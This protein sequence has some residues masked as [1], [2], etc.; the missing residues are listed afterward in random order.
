ME[1]QKNQVMAAD[2]ATRIAAKIGFSSLLRNS[3]IHLLKQP[4][5]YQAHPSSRHLD[6]T[7]NPFSQ[8]MHS[9]LFLCLLLIGP[10]L[11]SCKEE[12]AHAGTVPAHS[13]GQISEGHNGNT[14]APSPSSISDTRE[15]AGTA[16]QQGQLNLLGKD[17]GRN[18]VELQAETDSTNQSTVEQKQNTAPTTGTV[19]RRLSPISYHK[20]SN[21]AH[22][23]RR[24]NGYG[25]EASSRQHDWLRSI[26]ANSIA[27]TPFGFQ[28]G[29]KSNQLVGFGPEDEPGTRDRS[30]KLDD[31]AA[32]VAS[33]HARG[34]RVMLKPHIWSSDFWDGS[35]WHGTID[36]T[37]AEDHRQWWNSY[38]KLILFYAEFAEQTKC[39]YYCIGTE[40]VQMTTTYPQ[41]WRTLIADV[42]EIFKGK[43]SYA[44]HWEQE[45][46][47]I[48][49]WDAL[50]FI[51]L[52]AY[53]PL[54]LPDSASTAQLVSAWQPH[55]K[56]ID[57]V[58]RK[59]NR[60]VVF[61][62]A[63][64]RP[65]AGTWRE[66]WLYDGGQYNPAAQGRAFDA[67]F[68]A[69]ANDTWFRGLYVWKSFTDD[70]MARR[71]GEQTGFLYKGLPGEEIL[72]KWWQR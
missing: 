59:F 36:Q 63:G 33:A 66:P 50:D 65:V 22:V 46:K 8:H 31:M 58:A 69:F 32:E 28:R 70:N 20:G 16:T 24:G 12:Q 53:F 35:E 64:Y 49:F 30:M 27:I 5:P 47:Q 56:A 42:R 4:I 72:K 38:R 67:L 19:P 23:H 13:S 45:W 55:R 29:A 9:Y 60:H 14:T 11:L 15:Q 48:T 7:S 3:W 40:L 1:I 25:S 34:L 17:T 41:E 54:N 44:A 52:G 18:S 2:T 6:L 21:H 57:S 62:E 39:D 26:G 71:V 61:L 37:S 10:L 43:I 68:Q 51:G